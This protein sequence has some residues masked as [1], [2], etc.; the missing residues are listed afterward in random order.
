MPDGF[1]CG[2]DGARAVATDVPLRLSPGRR[3]QV[4]CASTPDGADVREIALTAQQS[5]PL[6]REVRVRSTAID[7]GVLAVRLFDAEGRAV[8][9]A[10]VTVTND[11]GVQID[12]IR[13][14]RERGVY[15]AS[16]RWPRGVT[17]ARFRF[18]VNGAETFEEDLSQ[19]D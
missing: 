8:P 11:R 15:N 7:Q 4:R 13:E 2:I 10:D 3:H 5:G 19:G 1:F 6:L 14:A 16:M 17:R 18:T 9:Y 12:R